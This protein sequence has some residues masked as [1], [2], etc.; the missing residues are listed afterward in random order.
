MIGM[1]Y[2]NISVFLSYPNLYMKNWQVF[3]DILIENL[4]KHGLESRTL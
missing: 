4:T 2:M 1:M 3:I